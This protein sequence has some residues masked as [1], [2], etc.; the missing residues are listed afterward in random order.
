MK[1]LSPIDLYL[2][3]NRTVWVL[4]PA[5]LRDTR[6]AR[7][8]GGLLHSLV[9]QR[10]KRQQF[11]GTFFLR[12]RPQIEQIR[13]VIQSQPHGA[14][15]KVAVLG[16]STGAEVY[17]LLWTIRSARP[18]LKLH[19]LAVDISPEILRIAE[20]GVYTKESSNSPGRSIFERLSNAELQEIFDWNGEK[21]TVKPWIRANI[22]WQL[23]DA[24][25]PELISDLGPQDIV[26]ASNFLCH[27]PPAFAE[28]C[29]RNIAHLV[30]TGGYLFVLGVDLAVRSKVA[31]ELGWQ[32]VP[33]LIRE[34]YDGD[35]SV[36]E[37][38]PLEWWGLEPLDDKRR[39]WQL[40]Y[41]VAYRTENKHEPHLIA[42]QIDIAEKRISASVDGVSKGLTQ[43][44]SNQR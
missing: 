15:L 24:A 39:D 40:R 20:A 41:A 16:C 17:S 35:P 37:S 34:I 21:A 44:H 7:W 10:A 25:D 26:L 43:Q 33:D 27:M 30:G 19:T 13:R 32:P 12:N 23:G 8:Y 29:L 11:F 1:A 14:T 18:D 28:K 3:I 31:R 6:V 5:A 22:T 36:R 2:R 9:C 38:W 4:L 42:A